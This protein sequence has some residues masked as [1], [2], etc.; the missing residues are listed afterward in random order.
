MTDEGRRKRIQ[1]AQKEWYARPEPKETLSLSWRGGPRILPVVELDRDVP[2]LNTKSH[3]LRAQLESDPRGER[4]LLNPWVDESQAV[5]AEYLRKPETEEE[6]L[7]FKRLKDNLAR[8]GQRQPGVITRDGVL[9]NANRRLVALRDLRDTEKR[10]IRVA[11]LP[12]DAEPKEL[13]ELELRL[14]MQEELK[15]A[16]SLTNELLFIEELA[17]TYKMTDEQIAVTL[18]WMTKK[19]SPDAAQVGQHRRILGLIREMQKLADTPVLLKFFDGKLE[20][21]KALE[22]KHDEM[23]KEDPAAAKRFLNAWLLTALAGFSSVHQIRSVGTTFDEDYLIP[24]LSEHEMLRDY[25]SVLSS[26]SSG[27]SPP[28]VDD[29]ALEDADQG[30]GEAGVDLRPLIS[31]L[32]AR[33]PTVVMPNGTTVDRDTVAQAIKQAAQGAIE[34]ER[35]EDRHEGRLDEP[36]YQLREAM[37]HLRRAIIS[38]SELKG[39][40]DFE[41]TDRPST[42]RYLYRQLRMLMKQLEE[43]EVSRRARGAPDRRRD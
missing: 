8:E 24:R 22:Q 9:Y 20:Q 39:T 25:A 5:V 43:I 10:W 17:R 31:I 27:A 15:V 36:V 19:G 34:D 37:R 35:A 28:G 26:T 2:L 32:T 12:E 1:E 33:T 7:N 18:R 14:Q 6:Q 16:Y 23:V 3:R 11:V 13:A 29:L 4:I 38:Y 21:L 30:A 41:Q 40:D 42:F